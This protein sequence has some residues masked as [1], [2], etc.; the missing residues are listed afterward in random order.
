M[1]SSHS[2]D[3]QISKAVSYV[4]EEC[5]MVLPGLQALFGFQLIVVFNDRFAE[6]LSP[7]EQQLH[8][9]AL[10]LVAMATA[11]VMTPAAYDR[12]TGLREVSERFL[13]LA[14]RLLLGAMTLLMLAI[15]LDFYVI[16]RLILLNT[17]LSLLLACLLVGLFLTLWFLL[18]RLNFLQ[19]L[20]H[21]GP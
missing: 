2:E 20:I 15:G 4:L 5:R 14:S 19:K 21:K 9:I 1:P 8:L 7:L 16:A 13:A 17:G 12:Q 11:L 3:L 6:K 18:P 10:S